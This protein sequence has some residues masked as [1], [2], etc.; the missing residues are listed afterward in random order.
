M[1]RSIVLFSLG[2]VEPGFLE[3]RLGDKS[4]YVLDIWETLAV[5]RILDGGPDGLHSQQH[6]FACAPSI[7]SL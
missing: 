5:S 6:A 1:I 2:S 4:H 3:K 7:S